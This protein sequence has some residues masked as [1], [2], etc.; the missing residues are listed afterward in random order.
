MTNQKAYIELSKGK[1]IGFKQMQNYLQGKLSAKEKYAIEKHLLDCEFC[2]EAFESFTKYGTLEEH[3]SKV[4]NLNHKIIAKSAETKNLISKKKKFPF[5]YPIAAAVALIF[6]ISYFFILGN[7]RASKAEF[8]EQR[9]ET[10]VLDSLKDTAKILPLVKENNLAQEKKDTTTSKE[11][12][13]SL[14]STDRKHDLVADKEKTK[15]NQNI[16]ADVNSAED[17]QTDIAYQDN[18]QADKNAAEESESYENNGIAT[19]RSAFSDKEEKNNT[20][21]RKSKTEKTANTAEMLK[22]LDIKVSQKDY[23]KALN[24]IYQLE[25]CKDK[26]KLKKRL[27]LTRARIFAAQMNKQVAVNY[28]NSVKE[29]KITQSKEYLKLL[30]SLQH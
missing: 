6:G 13:R 22:L 24:L 3:F 4:E 19:T 12:T 7:K 18:T 10:K 8:A 15:Q 23:S 2:S 17:N 30:D 28:L 1:C 27:I 9:K 11:K 25:H 21:V 5:A 14:E 20:Q 16:E 29:T 26:E